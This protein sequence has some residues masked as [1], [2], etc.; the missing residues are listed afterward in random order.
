VTK[1][2]NQIRDVTIYGRS[3]SEDLTDAVMEE[4][5]TLQIISF[6][7]LTIK[8]KGIFTR[9][10]PVKIS[11]VIIYKVIGKLSHTYMLVRLIIPLDRDREYC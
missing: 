6:S 11:F 3:A 8:Q 7:S 2:V 4:P 1:D 5:H 9:T 10:L